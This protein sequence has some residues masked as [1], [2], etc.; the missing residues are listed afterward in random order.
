MKCNKMG[1]ERQNYALMG[2]ATEIH[3]KRCESQKILQR[4]TW[5]PNLTKLLAITC[6]RDLS[7]IIRNEV[8]KW[9]FF[10]MFVRASDL[11]WNIFLLNFR[12]NRDAPAERWTLNVTV[13]LLLLELEHQSWLWVFLSRTTI[14][15]WFLKRPSFPL[16]SLICQGNVLKGF[17]F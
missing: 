7:N 10:E 8:I 6:K 4:R 13:M 9:R 5:S 11:L 3:S 12:F 14:A 16:I 15:G 17:G 1:W 2:F